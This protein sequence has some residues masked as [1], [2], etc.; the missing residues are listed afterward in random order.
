VKEYTVTFIFDYAVMICNPIEAD[1]EDDAFEQAK[2]Y[3][4][5]SGVN[6]SNANY[7]LEIEESVDF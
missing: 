1:N 6:I 4:A 5:N 7:R 2:K 3:V